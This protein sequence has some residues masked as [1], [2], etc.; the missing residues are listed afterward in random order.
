MSLYLVQNQS[1]TNDPTL[2]EDKLAKAI[3]EVFSNGA[4]T[5]EGLVEGLNETGI[6]GPDGSPWSAESFRDE[7]SRLEQSAVGGR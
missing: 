5:L 6:H 3:E 2:Y 7:I 4:H 1:R